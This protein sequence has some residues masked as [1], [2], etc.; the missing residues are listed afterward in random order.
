MRF[1][2]DYEDTNG[3]TIDE[4]G[5]DLPIPQLFEEFAA[6]AFFQPKGDL[7]EGI[8]EGANNARQERMKRTCRSN[9]DGDPTLLAACGTAGS[10]SRMTELGHYCAGVCK[11]DATG[12]G[13]FDAAPFATEQLNIQ[14]TFEQFDLLAQWGL[15]HAEPLSRA[16]DMP[17]LSDRDK[18]AKVP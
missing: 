14:L 6:E 18:I 16:R 10:F 12:L 7:R 1:Y 4:D 9:P 5:I 11:V 2:F 15:L 13:Q 3:I 17:F 8:P